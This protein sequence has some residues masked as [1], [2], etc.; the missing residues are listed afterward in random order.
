MILKVQQGLLVTGHI[1]CGFLRDHGIE[2]A[3]KE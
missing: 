1:L 3:R 2:G